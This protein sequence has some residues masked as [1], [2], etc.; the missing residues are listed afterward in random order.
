[1]PAIGIEAIVVLSV[2]G[3]LMGWL[4]GLVTKGGGFGTIGNTIVGVGGA[5]LAYYALDYMGVH[6]GTNPV[7]LILTAASGAAALLFIIG[8]VRRKD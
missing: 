2:I 5:F 6:V 4:G 1:M 3:I 7:S 8:L